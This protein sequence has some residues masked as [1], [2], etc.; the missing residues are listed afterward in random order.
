LREKTTS[1]EEFQAH[2]PGRSLGALRNT[3]Y[4]HLTPQAQDC[5][6]DAIYGQKY[7]QREVELL[8]RMNTRKHASLV[9]VAKKLGR[10]VKSVEAKWRRLVEDNATLRE[11]E[12]GAWSPEEDEKLIR[13]WNAGIDSDEIHHQ[14]GV[15]RTRTSFRRR[16][17]L[18]LKHRINHAERRRNRHKARRE[19]K[20][21][22]VP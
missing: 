20:T 6:D 5:R 21:R 1:W 4:R 16:M 13:L 11:L 8:L 19:K 12:S 10:T 14:L 2:F 3:Y 7:S 9:E 18:H 22:S 15:H 17:R